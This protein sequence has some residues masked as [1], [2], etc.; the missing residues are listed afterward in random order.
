MKIKIIGL[1]GFEDE[2]AY[3]RK[4]GKYCYD[5]V[6]TVKY[7]SDLTSDEVN[8]ILKDKDYY[9]NQYNADIMVVIH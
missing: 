6:N 2:T 9:L 7:A 4:L 1:Y 8:S 3:F 5:F